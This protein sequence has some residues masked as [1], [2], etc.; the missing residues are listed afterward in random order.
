MTNSELRA[1]GLAAWGFEWQSPLSRALG[2]N[3]RTVA[4]WAAGETTIPEAVSDEIRRVL[5][6]GDKVNPE[7]PRDEWIVGVGAEPLAGSASREYIIHTVRPRFVARVVNVDEEGLPVAGEMPADTL[8]GVCYSAA[9][10]LICE[11]VWI[12]PPPTE[13]A[14]K[15][16]LDAAADA[17][18]EL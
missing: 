18:E 2:V 8:T 1:L 14:L 11:I 10:S 13:R 7:W 5:G 17:L 4:R 12:D 9:D 16:L 6:V 3:K 15:A